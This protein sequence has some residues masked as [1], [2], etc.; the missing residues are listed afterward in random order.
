MGSKAPLNVT[1]QSG[2][3]INV[4]N[5]TAA[6]RDGPLSYEDMMED[7]LLLKVIHFPE[8]HLLILPLQLKMLY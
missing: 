4:Y 5:V 1:I 7:P 2:H 6:S 3:G 8:A